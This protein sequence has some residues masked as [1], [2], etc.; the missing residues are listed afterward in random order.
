[1]LTHIFYGI[2]AFLIILE[3][4]D[5]FGVRKLITKTEELEAWDMKNP[6]VDYEDKPKFYKDYIESRTVSTWTFLLWA[7]L[8]LFTK[9]NVDFIL[10]FIITLLIYPK[11]STA[12]HGKPAR[13]FYCSINSLFVIGFII[14]EITKHYN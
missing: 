4:A 5:L 2:G 13:Y 1:M 9:Y 11:L 14:Y 7:V 12:L 6:D 10:F 3:L 8:G